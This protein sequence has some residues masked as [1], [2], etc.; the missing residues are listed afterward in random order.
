MTLAIRIWKDGDDKPG[1]DEHL[2]TAKQL[3]DRTQRAMVER[4]GVALAV[5]DA[6]IVVEIADG[7]EGGTV[8]FRKGDAVLAVGLE[9]DD[10]MNV[11]SRDAADLEPK[12]T[13]AREAADKA[14][15]DECDYM[16]L[17]KALT[18]LIHMGATV[19]IDPEAPAG[20]VVV[21]QTLCGCTLAAKCP[22]AVSA[23][24]EAVDLTNAHLQRGRKGRLDS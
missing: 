8:N 16:D 19:T 17:G 22:D 24:R 18:M 12:G 5:A 20:V 11:F 10:A 9:T 15:D 13:P 6:A 1:G 3:I 14:L 4:F 21:A 7:E 2:E 23:L